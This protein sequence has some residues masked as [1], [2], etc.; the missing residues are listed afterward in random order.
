MAYDIRDN[1]T[2]DGNVTVSG[3]LSITNG[4]SFYIDVNGQ[5]VKNFRLYNSQD[6]L[7]SPGAGNIIYNS[8]TKNT[9]GHSS[10]SRIAYYNGGTWK[11]L[12]N[13]TLDDYA[14][15]TNAVITNTD[16]ISAA[17]EKTQGQINNISSTKLSGNENIVV[18]GDA[19]GSGTT[20]I[21]L[22]LANSGVSASTY[23]KV[24]VN[25]KGLVTVGASLLA[26]DLPAHATTHKSSGS[27]SI[28]INELAT[29]NGAVSIGDAT[30]KYQ[31]IN[32]ADGTASHHAVTYAQLQ[33]A[34]TGI[35]PKT[36]AKVATTESITLSGAQTID[37]VSVG[38][39]DRVLVKDQST[40]SQN[41]IYAVATGA[42]TRVTDADAIGEL[43]AAYIFVQSGTING[44]SGWYCT[45]ISS[46]VLGTTNITWVL[47][48]AS[49]N[50]DADGST[51]IKTGNILSV[52]P[53][54]RT[55]KAVGACGTS[56][57]WTFTHGL[58]TA[59][60]LIQIYE[61]GTT[62]QVYAGVVLGVNSDTI[63]FKTTPTNEQYT[64]IAI[65]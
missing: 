22:T 23:T 40:G 11:Y 47:F 25:A 29:A 45:N 64:A 53:D 44:N 1:T 43:V 20:A 18:S 58:N 4:G 51:I 12:A 48:S 33:A 6:N 61:T 56:A 37:G 13:D 14:T 2:I 8:S 41:G 16:T 27:D 30:N 65:G 28:R 7:S 17:F 31:I 63:T 38:A 52:A 21:A 5:E 62:K 39:G 55:K 57:T 24:T 54:Y 32:V 46:D 19:T 42:W 60:H 9:V 15:P 59:N 50:L 3:I 49:D 36:A 34:Q 35:Q 26:S 10:S